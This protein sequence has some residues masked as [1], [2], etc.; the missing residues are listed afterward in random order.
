MGKC[1]KC[2][3]P[4]WEGEGD[5]CPACKSEKAHWIKK[6]IGATV[7]VIG[8]AWGVIEAIGGGDGGGDEDDD[9]DWD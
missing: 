9:E 8:I 1:N 5:L 3:R 2:S 6:S 7:V 4:L